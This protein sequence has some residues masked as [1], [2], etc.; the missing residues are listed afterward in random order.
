MSG[1]IRNF[2]LTSVL[3]TRKQLPHAFTRL[4]L[5]KMGIYISDIVLGAATAFIVISVMTTSRG[6][7]VAMG[8]ITFIFFVFPV[9]MFARK[10][11]SIVRFERSVGRRRRQMRGDIKA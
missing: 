3:A 10:F 9:T 11:K 8:K 1:K 2:T 7:G 6:A 4:V 5:L